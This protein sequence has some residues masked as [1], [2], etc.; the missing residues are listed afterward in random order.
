MLSTDLVLATINMN[1]SCAPLSAEERIN[2]MSLR[3]FIVERME[4]IE[5]TNCSSEERSVLLRRLQKRANRVLEDLVD[6]DYGHC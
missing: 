3:A 5:H 6:G 2:F 1:L 4:D